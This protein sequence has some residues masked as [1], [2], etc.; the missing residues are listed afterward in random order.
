MDRGIIEL[1]GPN[2]FWKIFLPITLG[3]LVFISGIFLSF[4]SLP[5]II[6]LN[7]NSYTENLFFFLNNNNY[8]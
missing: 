6:E 1:L 3:Y 2:G 4:H 8:A 5:K 7:V